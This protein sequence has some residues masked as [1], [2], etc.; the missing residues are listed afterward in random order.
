[1]RVL[2]AIDGSAAAA[3]AR[4]LVDRIAWPPETIIR[5]VGRRSSTGDEVVGLPG[6]AARRPIRRDVE[7]SVGPPTR[8]RARGRPPRPASTTVGRVERML[9]RGRPAQRDRRRRPSDFGAD[10][11][12]VGNRGHGAGSNTMLLGS[13]PAEVVDHAPCPV[14]VARGDDRH[15]DPARDRRLAPSEHAEHVLRDWPILAGRPVDGRVRRRGRDAVEHRH[16]AGHL[17]LGARVVHDGR[18]RGSAAVPRPSP[19]SPA[20]GS[21]PSASRRRPRSARVAPAEEIV[22][23]AR[24]AGRP[25]RGRHARPH[26]ARPARARAASPARC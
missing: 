5:V 26:R 14:L 3:R 22:A 25:H 24:A 13:C 19:T 20:S 15:A 2:L 23:A 16:V 4:D 6:R 8:R 10:L 9:L 12:V 21:G 1:M 18:R 17:R 7:T 11:I